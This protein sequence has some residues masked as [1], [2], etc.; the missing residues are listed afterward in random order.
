MFG[1]LVFGYRV[2]SLAAARSDSVFGYLVFGYRVLSG[3]GTESDSV[4]GY[5]WTAAGRCS[6][7]QCAADPLCDLFHK[8]L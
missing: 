2:L 3:G 5:Q 7:R 4:F 6:W 1:Y 8:T